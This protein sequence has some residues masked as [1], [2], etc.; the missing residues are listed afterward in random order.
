M[1]LLDFVQDYPGEPAPKG[2]TRKIKPIW[3]GSGISRAI[4]KPALDPDTY[5]YQH[6]TTQ[7]FYRQDALPATQ[8]TVSKH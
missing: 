3:S 5:P 7:F 6:P 4:R 1:A 8:P 2:K